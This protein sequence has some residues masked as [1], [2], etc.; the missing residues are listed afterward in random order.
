MGGDHGPSV[1]VPG[2]DFAARANP[3][4]RFLLHGD[5]A[6]INAELARL[7]AARAVCEVRHTDKAISMD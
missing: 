3:E 5:A 4:L 7:P 2:V 1:V 6:R